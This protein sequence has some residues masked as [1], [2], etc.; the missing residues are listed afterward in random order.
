M[1]ARP[2]LTT[3]D[4]IAAR[5]TDRPAGGTQHKKERT[6]EEKAKHRERVAAVKDALKRSATLKGEHV[7]PA[8]SALKDW[9]R[10]T[11]ETSDDRFQILV[12]APFR[13]PAKKKPRY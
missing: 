6:E 2:R 8:R 11:P 7:G 13:E 5:T 10:E 3:A 1:A 4:E 9:L 12:E